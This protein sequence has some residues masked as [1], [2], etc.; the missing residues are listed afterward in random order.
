MDSL[1]LDFPASAVVRLR[2]PDQ[3]VPH[4]VTFN[5]QPV[6]G[7][8]WS[9]ETLEIRLPAQSSTG[10]LSIY[11]SR[12]GRPRQAGEIELVSL[13]P[14]A[15][16]SYPVAW[17][18][19]LP[20]GLAPISSVFQPRSAS[21]GEFALAAATMIHQVLQRSAAEH[22]EERAA[23]QAALLEQLAE[24]RALRQS[25]PSGRV[26]EELKALENT[27]A[28]V[29]GGGTGG[30][31]ATPRTAE[32]AWRLEPNFPWSAATLAYVFTQEPD[33]VVVR[34]SSSRSA[35]WAA[36]LQQ[37]VVALGL[38]ALILL[39]ARMDAHLVLLARV[40]PEC[41]LALG[42]L[43]A[44]YW[45]SNTGAFLLIALGLFARV[46]RM[47]QA[48]QGLLSHGRSSLPGRSALPSTVVR[49]S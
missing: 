8:A 41:L 12:A 22:A 43:L 49:P 29:E 2:L 14:A 6:E 33:A 40:W 17:Q 19:Q 1:C 48:R 5:G 9:E 11:W 35:Q 3:G 31:H 16:S 18:I 38:A 42:G 23:L 47:V 25:T 21:G 36:V 13:E 37:T 34:V 20:A 4:L 45:L 24:G 44:W 46:W 28:A 30:P 32:V 10:I 39:L 15:P 27:Y 7:I 26:L